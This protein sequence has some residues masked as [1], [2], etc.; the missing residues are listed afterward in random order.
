MVLS[1]ITT[2]ENAKCK[3][4]KENW[5]QFPHLPY[6]PEYKSNVWFSFQNLP[7]IENSYVSRVEEKKEFGQICKKQNFDL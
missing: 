5:N 7:K 2:E 6:I 3:K 1:F 4:K